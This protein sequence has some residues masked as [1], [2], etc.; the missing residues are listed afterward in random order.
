MLCHCQV[1]GPD[2]PDDQY[3]DDRTNYVENEVAM[4][5]NAG[6]QGLVAGLAVKQCS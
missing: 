5:Y 6:F 1:G 3:N 2:A 4:D